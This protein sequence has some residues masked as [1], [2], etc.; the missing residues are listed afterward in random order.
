MKSGEF[1]SFLDY[2]YIALM[3]LA[4]AAGFVRGFIKDF[5]STC[6]WYGSGFI[7]VLVAPY[8]IPAVSQNISNIMLARTVAIGIAYLVVLAVLLLIINM[9]SQN[10]RKGILSGIDR[11]AGVLFGLFKSAAV[12]ICLHMLMLIFEVKKD[13]YPL[14]ENSKLSVIFFNIAESWMP[15]ISKIGFIKSI[16]M[17]HIL[18]KEI[19]IEKPLP[20]IKKEKLPKKNQIVVTDDQINNK[21]NE[22]LETENK[23]K[24]NMLSKLKELVT[25]LIIK[26]E[27]DAEPEITVPQ[28]SPSEIET[29][30]LINKP[31]YGS[32]S[33]MEART[34]R[35]KQRKAAKLKK[36]LQKHLDS[37]RL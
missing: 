27:I 30:K 13:K 22:I 3:F 35:R 7:A 12:L 36:A 6:A 11:A 31:K 1:F 37:E 4:T 29:Q 8:L 21:T 32:M 5:L 17:S 19:S 26:R 10:V 2:V 24:T 14:L 18:E 15:K 25:N 28:K 16:Q 33:L 34:K 9:I 23:E 20:T